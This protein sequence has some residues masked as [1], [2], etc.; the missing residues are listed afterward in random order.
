MLV[1]VLVL[2]WLCHPTMLPGS[3]G[4]FSKFR[5]PM[6][7][8]EGGEFSMPKKDWDSDFEPCSSKYPYHLDLDF[9]RHRFIC[10][11]RIQIKNH[12]SGS[13]MFS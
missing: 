7:C 8:W 12:V 10:H 3:L 6:D 9:Q 5:N 4:A 11:E 1:L 2:V 13:R